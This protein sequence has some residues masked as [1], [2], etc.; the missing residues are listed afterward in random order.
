MSGSQTLT[1]ALHVYYYLPRVHMEK[2]CVFKFS[3][4]L[5][6]DS[7]RFCVTILFL[8]NAPNSEG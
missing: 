4:F 6:K 1:S 7:S 5:F 8:P 2:M 3:A